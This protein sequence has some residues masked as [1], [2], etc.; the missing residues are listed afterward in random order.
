MKFIGIL[1]HSSLEGKS[2][3]SYGPYS[4]SDSHTVMRKKAWEKVNSYF[5]EGIY[6]MIA[7]VEYDYDPEKQT[8]SVEVLEKKLAP[9]PNIIELN[10][11]AKKDEKVKKKPTKKAAIIPDF[12]I[13]D[14]VLQ[15]NLP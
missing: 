3:D 11:P 12:Y 4:S 9:P 2:L 14:D 10:L 6:K 15:G 7:Q 5:N 8:F 1:C 13:Y